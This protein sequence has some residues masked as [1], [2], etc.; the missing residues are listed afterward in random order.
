MVDWDEIDAELWEIDENLRRSE[1]SAAEEA[2]CL[3]RRKKLWRRREDR[4][5]EGGKNLPTSGQQKG[6]AKAA[7]EAAGD[8]KRGINQKI[9]IET[10]L[11]E[12]MLSAIAGTSL[13]KGVEMKA[14][15]SLPVEERANV[16]SPS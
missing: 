15:A 14:L 10:E 9:A 5:K 2:L 7:A 12:E 11:G 6:F 16:G 1:L 8:S 13:D 4:D 3:K